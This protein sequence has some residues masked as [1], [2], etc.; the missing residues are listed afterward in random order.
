MQ[1]AATDEGPFEEAS[2]VYALLSKVSYIRRSP[3]NHAENKLP[4]AS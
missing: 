4:V 1:R 3:T 2:Q